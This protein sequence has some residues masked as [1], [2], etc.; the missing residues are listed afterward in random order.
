[1][2]IALEL[3]VLLL[4][5]VFNGVLAMS[6]LALVSARKA[7]L[8]QRA[9]A[10]DA[11]AAAALAL[12]EEP[13]R[14]LST[15]QIGITMVGILAGAFG[16]AT[17]AET[18]AGRLRDAGLSD[19]YAQTAG[20]VLV[21]LAITYLSLVVGELVPKRLAMNNPERVASRMA[22]PMRV[23]AAIA[24]PAVTLL[25]ISTELT[26]RLLGI[27]A[28]NDPAV[29][30][31][32]IKLAIQ[33]GTEA[34]VLDE[35]E[36]ELVTSVFR[37]AD[38]R[39][40][41]LMTPRP[42]VVWLDLD[43]PTDAVVQEM[44]ASPYLHFPIC[45]GDLDRVLGIVSV[46]DLW[47]QMVSGSAIDLTTAVRPALFLP[48]TMPALRALEAVKEAHAQM[49]LVVDEFGGT[50][51]LITLTDLLEAIVGDLPPQPGEEEPR[52]VRRDDGSWLIDGLLPIDELKKTL[53][54]TH[55]PDEGE[56]QT[57][58]GFV[59]SR[60]G[61]IPAAGDSFDWDSLRFEVVDMDGNRVDKVLV[62]PG[63]SPSP[64]IAR[65]AAM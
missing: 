6:E 30:E 24:R 63:A 52:A 45:W 26:L 43:D 3:A 25:T 23:L 28:S 34:G 46:R 15:V 56:Y 10:G 36:E 38:R 48:E 62:A 35:A 42:A 18:I 14:F 33:Q 53:G 39:V 22:R 31:E 32:E 54:V 9:A 12:A 44:V 61:R 1:M 8:R 51:G 29:T 47:I 57:L 58:A 21:V 4:L 65:R 7:R 2:T 49:A 59:I 16:G 37:L 41:E 11:G 60:L 20:V 19:A 17:L 5:I 50:A 13:T 55:L 27:R 40:G 64:P